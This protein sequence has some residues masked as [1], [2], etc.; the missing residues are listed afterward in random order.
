MC[1]AITLIT[2][3][4][5]I[6]FKP[7]RKYVIINS[8]LTVEWNALATDWKQHKQLGILGITFILDSSTPA[9]FTSSVQCSVQNAGNTVSSI[10]LRDTPIIQPLPSKLSCLFA[11]CAL[12]DATSHCSS[13]ICNKRKDGEQ[14]QMSDVY[15]QG[16]LQIHQMLTWL[17]W[18]HGKPPWDAPGTQSKRNALQPN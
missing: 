10:S 7:F 16:L 2:S 3:T 11:L 4:L 1:F 5:N 9:W 6:V 18:T 17:T 8:S 13:T 14:T 12:H 15:Q